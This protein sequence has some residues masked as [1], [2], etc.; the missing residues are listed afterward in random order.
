[1]EGVKCPIVTAPQEWVVNCEVKS[2]I[3]FIS[4][5]M[6]AL[7][8]CKN[9]IKSNTTHLFNFIKTEFHCRQPLYLSCFGV[10]CHFK[11]KLE[12][13]QSSIYMRSLL[14][15]HTSLPLDYFT[16]ECV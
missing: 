11:E 12:I 3:A 8:G 10:G 16:T 15:S 4:R 14:L 9:C 5:F 1:M 2:L 7:E 13:Q 6:H